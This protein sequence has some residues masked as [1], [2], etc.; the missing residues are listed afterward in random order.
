VI[1]AEKAGGFLFE[2]RHVGP[3]DEAGAIDDSLDTLLNF[4]LQ[5]PVLGLEVNHGDS[6]G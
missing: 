2:G 1:S 4:I 6:H 5:F 3:Q